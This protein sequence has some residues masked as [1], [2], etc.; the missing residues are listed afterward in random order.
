MSMYQ[1]RF[2]L[3]QRITECMNILDDIRDVY[4]IHQDMRELSVDEMA[5][6]LTGIQHLYQI[7]FEL[8]FNT[9]E[10]HLK[11]I[12]ENLHTC[13][14]ACDKGKQE[15]RDEC[16]CHHSEEGSE[17]HIWSSGEDTW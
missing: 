3:E 4:T 14:S 6:T 8:L 12:H 17:K 11:A 13:Q 16:P 10:K 2:V 7:K 15:E 5:N 1:Y 9:F